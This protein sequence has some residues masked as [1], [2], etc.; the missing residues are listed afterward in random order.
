MFQFRKRR[1]ATTESD[2]QRITQSSG[3]KLVEF[4]DNCNVHLGCASAV[5][6]DLM[7]VEHVGARRDR[8]DAYRSVARSRALVKPFGRAIALIE[9]SIKDV[10][11]DAVLQHLDLASGDHPA[12]WAP[13]P[14]AVVAASNGLSEK[15]A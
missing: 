15:S 12:A 5:F 1:L 3:S 7:R 10:F 9:T 13:A 8:C 6:S 11:G 2:Y 4:T 14:A